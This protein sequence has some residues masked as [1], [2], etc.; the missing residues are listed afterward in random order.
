VL[1]SLVDRAL[2]A[3]RCAMTFFPSD[4]PLSPDADFNYDPTTF[5]APSSACAQGMLRLCGFCGVQTFSEVGERGVFHGFS[6][7]QGDD[8]ERAVAAYGRKHVAHA[9]S[10]VLGQPVG[11]EQLLQELKGASIPEFGQIRQSAAE[12]RAKEWQHGDR[13]RH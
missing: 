13:W 8:A 10:R 1:G 2:E 6:P 9:A 3:P 12:A 5:W 7:A 4:E 11:D